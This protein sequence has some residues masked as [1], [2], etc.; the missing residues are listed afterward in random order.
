MVEQD[1]TKIWLNKGSKTG[2]T[3][4]LEQVG[5]WPKE[6]NEFKKAEADTNKFIDILK[7]EGDKIPEPT[8]IDPVS[9]TDLDVK[10]DTPEVIEPRRDTSIKAPWETTSRPV[11]LEKMPMATDWESITEVDFWIKRGKDRF[12]MPMI[13]ENWK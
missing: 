1:K 12:W 8:K 11:D 4:L 3:G 9:P 10:V 7:Q 5:Q 13:I 2:R 6:V